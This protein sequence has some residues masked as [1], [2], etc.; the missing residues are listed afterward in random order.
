M[1]R[2]GKQIRAFVLKPYSADERITTQSLQNATTKSPTH[3]INLSPQLFH[4]GSTGSGDLGTISQMLLD[5]QFADMDRIISYDDGFFG[6]EYEGM[7]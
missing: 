5:Q 3:E 4:R 7:W 2:D 1:L 6:S